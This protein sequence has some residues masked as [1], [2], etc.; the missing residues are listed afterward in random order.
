MTFTAFVIKVHMQ[1]SGLYSLNI[2][3]VHVS[4]RVRQGK[5]GA[6]IE[7]KLERN[8]KSSFTFHTVYIEYIQP[9]S[10]YLYIY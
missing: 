1:P 8:F 5:R 3:Y 10:M 9:L 4:V 7:G 6:A 2:M